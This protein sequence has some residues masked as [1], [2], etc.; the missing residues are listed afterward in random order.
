M[1]LGTVIHRFRVY[2]TLAIGGAIA[3]ACTAA[4]APGP[5]RLTGEG[6]SEW[7]DPPPPELPLEPDETTTNS[8]IFGTGTRP[9]GS[10]ISNRDAGAKDGGAT[11]RMCG[12]AAA[13]GDLAVVE[14]MIASRSGSNDLG[15]W[16]E[17]QS[18]RDCWVS[19][20]G[21]TIASPRGGAAA[22]E[23]TITE[24]IDLPPRA[25]FVVASSGDSVN[26]DGL[27]GLV[28]AFDAS[29]VL[30]NAGD[31]IQ[32]SRGDVSIDAVT[33][34]AFSNVPAGRSVSFPSDCAWADRG[35]W[36]RWSL[37]YAELGHGRT[38]T[39]NAE[40]DDVTCF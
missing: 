33:Y 23:V 29:D 8:G 21:V 16:F 30:K 5:R 11:K 19:L 17:I 6:R 38:G 1:S 24:A 22:N 14:I 34:P 13:A 27:P 9:S 26:N 3:I 2:A 39:P 40:N 36:A 35:D 31:T 4:P 37:S 15:E 25:T 12:P 10:L 18:T 28:F 7:P 32:I 20:K